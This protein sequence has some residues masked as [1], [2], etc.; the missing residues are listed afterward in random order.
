MHTKLK[1]SAIATT[2][3]LF[4]VFSAPAQAAPH[5]RPNIESAFVLEA[6]EATITYEKPRVTTTPAPVKAKVAQKT[7]LLAAP[8]APAPVAIP[9]VPVAPA[10]APKPTTAPPSSK[11]STIASAALGQIGVMQDCTKLVT[12]SLRAVGIN[13]HGWPVSYLSLG[14]V[15]SGA[16][17]QPGDLI[18]YANGGAGVA[19]IAVYIGNGQAVHGGYNGNQTRIFTAYVPT[20]SAPVFIRVQ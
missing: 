6:P 11:G 16:E 17:A 5:P 9:P 7:V 18:Y 13:H 1:I 20:G 10:A 8:K 12:N 15:V 4:A 2:I 3:T 19:H 14:T